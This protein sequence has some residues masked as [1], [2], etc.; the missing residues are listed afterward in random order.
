MVMDDV[1]RIIAKNLQELRKQ[2]NLTQAELADKLNYSDK[3]IS[4]WEHGE[5]LPDIEVLCSLAEMYGVTVD[6]LTHEG[7]AEE[8][9]KYVKTD[10]KLGDK[11]AIAGLM[12]TAVWFVAAVIYIYMM[13]IVN[14]SAWTV[15]LWAVPAS[16]IVLGVVNARWGKR[17]Y[18]LIVNSVFVWSALLSACF[19]FV[20]Y[21]LWAMLIIGL[22]IQ[23]AIIL[24]YRIKK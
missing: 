15:F 22:P 5:S 13:L 19:Q 4:K 16:M 12:V 11:I 3:S 2:H 14:Y 18:G 9:A 23:V 7:S 20:S 21:N 17:L 24:L 1:K 6:F 8:K 10:R